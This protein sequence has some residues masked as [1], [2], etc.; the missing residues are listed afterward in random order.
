MTKLQGVSSLDC[1]QFL[2]LLFIFLCL[3]LALVLTLLVHS[4][5]VRQTNRNFEF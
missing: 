2:H 3:C 1:K 5:F 4:N